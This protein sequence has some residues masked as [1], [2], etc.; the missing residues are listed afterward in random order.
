[1]LKQACI[2]MN[3]VYV[4]EL[5]ELVIKEQ[6]EPNKQFIQHLEDLYKRAK[7]ESNEYK[8]PTIV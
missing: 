2:K 8:V 1:M 6:I 3:F 5:M 7:R 4:I